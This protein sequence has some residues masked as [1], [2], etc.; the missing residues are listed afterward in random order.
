ML[1]APL[2]AQ[3]VK[4]LP[5][6]GDLDWIPGSGKRPGGGHGC[7]LQYSCP[8]NS[9]D[10]AAWWATIHGVPKSRTLSSD[11]CFPLQGNAQNKKD[12][13]KDGLNPNCFDWRVEELK[14]KPRATITTKTVD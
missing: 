11:L 3:T 1:R 7:P 12:K 5:A 9:V 2:E 6:T 8:E 4:D 14:N 10:R 13:R